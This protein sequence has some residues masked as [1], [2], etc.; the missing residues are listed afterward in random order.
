M[1]DIKRSGYKLNED[2]MNSEL[3]KF[4]KN[5]GKNENEFQQSIRDDG[6]NSDYFRKKFETRLLINRYLDEKMLVGASTQYEKQ[7]IFESWFK[8][9]KLLAEVVYY[10]KDLEKI[11]L[12]SSASG[13]CCAAR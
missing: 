4:I 12:N 1:Q 10:D 5:S 6:Y 3:K 9:S 11:A 13:S 2:V 8:N 7:R